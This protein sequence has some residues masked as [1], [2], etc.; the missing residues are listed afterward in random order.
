MIPIY[1]VALFFQGGL[2]RGRT[3]GAVK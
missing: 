3:V 2:V 1:L